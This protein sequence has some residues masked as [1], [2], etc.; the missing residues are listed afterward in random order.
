V[1]E[2][3][4][5]VGRALQLSPAV[6]WL[7]VLGSL[8]G[9]AGVVAFSTRLNILSVAVLLAIFA[10]ATAATFRWP[11]LGLAAFAGL[12]PIEEILLIE[13]IG[14][15]SR[16]AG[17]LFAVTYG[18]PRI[19]RLRF[20]GM[21][22]GGWA[23]LAW[24][25]VSV[26]WAIDAA[27]AW[28]QLLTLIQLFLITVLVAD[29]VGHRPAI[30]RPLLWVYCISAAGTALIGI[31]SYLGT[32]ARSAALQGQN[33]AQFAAVLLPAL[34]FG[35]YELLNGNRR[36]AGGAVAL[37][38]TIGVIISGT[39]G[40]WLAVVVAIPLFV[41][42]ELSA[43]R[44]MAAIVVAVAMGVVVLQL[45]GVAELTA[46]RLDS[47]LTTGGAGRTDIWSVAATIFSSHPVLGVGYA[48]FPV[49]YTPEIV[50]ASGV[51][52]YTHA[53][54]A[55]H[56]LVVGT[57]VE[58][59]PVGLL[60]VAL[61]LGPL[62]LRRGWGPDA[63]TIQ[64]ILASLLVLSL[65]L[66]MLGNHKELWFAIGLSAGLAYRS[67]SAPIDESPEDLL[68]GDVGQEPLPPLVQVEAGRADARR[69]S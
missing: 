47:A 37:L 43:R 27:A 35:V 23:F 61:F 68:P 22:T 59:G 29:F 56:N 17:I 34:L 49:A 5:R 19:G 1:T 41:L 32:D 20:G 25:I 67:R 48:N 3:V 55:P 46:E 7:T 65:F 26:G 28:N 53:A 51:G 21:P 40:A 38:T 36:I 30:V 64:A 31:L 2:S 13:G 52:F 63:A 24:A 66:D 50:R 45:P 12:I 15:L 44:R 60:L 9:I 58:L 4:T 62:V 6:A 69:P 39:R 8:C 18:L 11:L 14:T 16:F 54:A 42:P 33:P 57:L 10:I